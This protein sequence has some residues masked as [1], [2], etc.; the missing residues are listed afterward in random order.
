[1]RSI[2][3]RLLRLAGCL[4]PALWGWAAPACNVPVFRYALER[5]E[6]DSYQIVVFLEGPLTAPQ[7]A[8]LKKLEKG[9]TDPAAN[10]T[11]TTVDLTREAPRPLRALWSAQKNPAAPWMVLRYPKQTRIERAAWT[12]PLSAEVVESLVESPARRQIAQRL[13]SGDA[14]V[15]LLLESGDKQRDEAVT[16]LVQAELRKLETSLVLPERSPADPA[17]NPDLPLKIAFSTVHVTRSNPAESMLVNMLLNWNTNLLARLEPMLFPIFGRG[18]VIPPAVGDEIRAEA[19]REMAEFLTG[20]CSCEL[21]ALN[22]GYDLLLA[23]NWNSLPA[24]QET[25]VPSLPSLVD[26]SQFAA[27]AATNSSHAIREPTVS[28]AAATKAPASVRH[29]RL[30]RNLAVVFGMGVVCLAVA[31]FVLKSRT[32]RER[33]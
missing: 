1:M 17:I 10:L 15:W 19:I 4:V 13:L 33:R 3:Y 20:P 7:Q 22:P 11:L 16:Q 32:H 9:V 28:L 27:A 2:G 21:K 24:Y 8:L 18:R 31:T 30:L 6:A 5:W 12:G 29:D 14:V 23:A 26:M 25:A